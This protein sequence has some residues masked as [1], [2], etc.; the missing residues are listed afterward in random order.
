M[1]RLKAALQFKPKQYDSD[2]LGYFSASSDQ[3]FTRSQFILRPSSAYGSLAS[4]SYLQEIPHSEFNY[5]DSPSVSCSSRSLFTQDG[6]FYDSHYGTCSADDEI[7]TIHEEAY[8]YSSGL[9]RSD[10][11]E[12]IYA[13]STVGR[14]KSGSDHY[15]L[16]E[17]FDD[18]EIQQMN[19]ESSSSPDNTL[20]R[21]KFLIKEPDDSSKIYFNEHFSRVQNVVPA[22]GLKPRSILKKKPS[23]LH[24]HIYEE[25]ENDHLCPI[26]DDVRPAP[27]ARPTV[28]PIRIFPPCQTF[29]PRR[30]DPRHISSSR[31]NH[32]APEVKRTTSFSFSFFTLNRKKKKNL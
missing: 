25:I 10:S 21:K 30:L 32:S 7:S 4:C 6:S 9:M 29:Q 18:L 26:P 5:E 11:E 27:P 16:E 12:S 13:A 19:Y 23:L 8:G 1:N 20:K 14:E 3:S 28:L 15:D 17:L 31:R 2:S 24:S 22:K